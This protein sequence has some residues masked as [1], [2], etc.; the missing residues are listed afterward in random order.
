MIKFYADTKAEPTMSGMGL[1]SIPKATIPV[2][3]SNTQHT[4][5]TIFR[6]W[7]SNY[8]LKLLGADT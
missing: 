4:L 8:P 1:N 7:Q 3:E 6:W 5:P 2:K